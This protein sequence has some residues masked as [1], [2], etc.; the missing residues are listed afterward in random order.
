MPVYYIVDLALSI[1]HLEVDNQ[2]VNKLTGEK[3]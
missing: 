2:L 1:L 3:D